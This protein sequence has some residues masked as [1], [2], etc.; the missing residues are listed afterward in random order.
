MTPT[1]SRQWG[2]VVLGLVLAAG[3]ARADFI[4]GITIPGSATDL[5]GGTKANDNRLGGFFSDLYYD[6][7]NNVYLGLPDRG[8]GGGV[9]AYDTRVQVFTLD[10]NK[11]TGAI[12]NFQLK[13]TIKFK[14][15]DGKQAFNGLNPGLLNGNK[16]VLGRSFDPE[17]IVK[18]S[19]GNLLVSD[20]YGPSAY[21]FKRVGLPNG[22]VE[23]RFV[24]AYQTPANLLP[25]QADGTP[26]FVDGRPTITTGRQDNRGFEGLA[27]SPDGRKVY[28]ALQ[29]P[30]VNEGASNDGRRSRNVRIVEFDTATGLPGKQF[31]YQLEALA[32]INARVPNNP[33]AA[34]AQGRNIGV[35][36]IIALNANEF[37]V[38]E[39]DNRGIGVDNP[40]GSVPVASKR[41][42]KIDLRGATDVSGTSLAGTNDLPPGVT[43]VSKSLLL[44]IQQQLAANG[45]PILEKF[46]GLA[47]G[48]RLD[49]GRYALLVG[50][51]NDFSVTQTGS[52]QQ[53]DVYTNGVDSVQVP[54]GDPGPAGYALLPTA[55]Y[56]FGERLPTFVP[57]AV[58]EPTGLGLL[59]AA[60]VA[61]LVARARRRGK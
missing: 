18:L 22:E 4:N 36:A 13:Q 25:K 53:F 47:V 37:L 21:E 45:I 5:G 39:R 23:A 30:L 20:E 42:Y 40:T 2:F 12:G 54:I 19:N 33:F 52:G 43:P 56:S 49:D 1:R 14:T 35:S 59:A 38:I 9:V 46:E 3:A 8:P 51:D 11:A 24:R 16:A 57:Q 6:R 60:G 41:V 15:A 61:G 26:N 28:A 44:D 32:D 17:G 58:P 27:I 34:T 31:V 48:P 55:L 29:D 50:T 10:V 7:T